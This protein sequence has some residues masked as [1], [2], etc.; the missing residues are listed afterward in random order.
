M[1]K[2]HDIVCIVCPTGCRLKITE[3]PNN[4][5]LIEGNTCRRGEEYGI[6]EVTNPT[7]VLTATVRIEGAHLRCLPVKTKEAIPKEKVLDVMALIRQ[8]TVQAPVEAGDI[9]IADVLGTGIDVV[10]TRRMSS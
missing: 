4:G 10:A 8:V 5:W 2:Q 3:T 1:A 7:R 6:K 9:I